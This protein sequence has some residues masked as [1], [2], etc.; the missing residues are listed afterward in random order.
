MSIYHVLSEATHEDLNQIKTL[1]TDILN[2]L[3]VGQKALLNN[4]KPVA[5]SPDALVI[6]F[7]YDILC[8]RAEEDNLLE[9][10]VNDY[11]EKVI[12]KRI[13]LLYITTE[14]WPKVRQDYIDQMK[15]KKSEEDSSDKNSED[16]DEDKI[17][18]KAVEY[19]GE[20]IV[21]VID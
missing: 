8:E 14:E 18:A 10:T 20:E 13:Q 21:E 3:D 2:L 9:N 7:A 19:F 16:R 5:A 6:E 1:W 15:D 4:A 12:D 11:L 17:V